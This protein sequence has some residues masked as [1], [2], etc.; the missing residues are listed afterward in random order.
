M[1]RSVKIVAIILFF[2]FIRANFAQDYE[3][4]IERLTQDVKYLADDKLEGRFPGTPGDKLAADYI[5][6][7]FK[8]AGLTAVGGAF[9]QKFEVVTG[10]RYGDGNTVEFQVKIP[11]LGIPMS[12]IKPVKR[13]WNLDEDYKPMAFSESGTVEGEMVFVGYGISAP[14]LGYDDYEGVDVK[15]KIV[16]MLT[17]SPGCKIEPKYR[18]EAGRESQLYVRFEFDN[19]AFSP[20]SDLR[21]KAKNARDRGAAAVMFVHV[22]H[23]SAN[24]LMPLDFSNMSKNSG[25]IAINANRTSIAKFFSRK[26]ALFSVE[27]EI[28]QT[29]KPKS[30]ALENATVKITVD[31]QEKKA[32][33]YNVF[34]AAEGS[35][36]SLENEYI[37]FGAHYDHLGWGGNTSTY[38][39][40]QPQI[41]NGAD[42]NASGVAAIIELARR[43]KENPMKRPAIFVAFGA[44]ELGV[45][46]SGYFV[47]NPPLPLEN[48]AAMINIDMIGRLRDNNLKIFGLK[49]SSML[50]DRVD[51]LAARD[52]VKITRM[53]SGFGPSDQSSFYA[54]N[55]PALQF[56]TGVHGDYH[57]PDDDWDKINY[58]GMA[59]AIDL[60][61]SV[62]RFMGDAAQKPPFTKVVEPAGSQ[63]RSHG[64]SKVW[65]GI[66]PNF[67]STPLGCKIS[68]TSPGSPAENAGLKADDVIT[69]INGKPIKNLY[70]LTYTLRE[71][72]PGDEIEVK[73]LRGREYK[74]EKKFKATLVPKK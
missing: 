9:R 34:A 54:K 24:V 49:T 43:V 13:T 39:E 1:L 11:R 68:G 55:I 33:T 62:A 63:K 53:G 57:H 59:H 23:D 40:R 20:Y 7:R 30:F 18:R 32:E 66:V 6:N 27:K 74:Q 2:S 37:V 69:E 64:A 61:E 48:M 72:N 73:V 67:E 46:G 65:F 10:I 14:Q 60:V 19:G 28:N 35:D 12:R 17:Q 45:Q 38:R 44:E 4:E 26:N 50:D 71:F 42:D 70:D 21:Y 36:P 31:L 16:I 25:I 8:E 5:E 3:G 51:T 56:F 22:N 15:N 47:E 41:H 52:S 29:Q 58:K